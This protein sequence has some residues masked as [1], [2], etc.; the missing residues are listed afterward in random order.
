MTHKTTEITTS[1]KELKELFKVIIKE[2]EKSKRHF[3]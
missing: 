2:T 1:I 3:K